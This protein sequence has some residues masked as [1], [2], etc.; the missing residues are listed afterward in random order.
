MRNDKGVRRSALCFTLPMVPG[1]EGRREAGLPLFGV[2]VLWAAAMA[3]MR[4][5]R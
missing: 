5:A 1:W 2:L 4:S 3:G